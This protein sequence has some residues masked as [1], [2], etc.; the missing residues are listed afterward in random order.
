MSRSSPWKGVK[1]EHRIP[2]MCETLSFMWLFAYRFSCLILLSS[3]RADINVSYDDEVYK[4]TLFQK[5]REIG[6]A[7]IVAKDTDK[8]GN[9]LMQKL[10]V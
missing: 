1:L 4:A 7:P 10:K 5:F 8:I 2:A 9:E 3:I 6:L